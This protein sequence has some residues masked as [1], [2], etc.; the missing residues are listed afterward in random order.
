MASAIPVKRS[1]RQPESGNPVSIPRA[2]S[3][4]SAR[5]G[6]G[7]RGF[8]LRLKGWLMERLATEHRCAPPGAA[9]SW[10]PVVASRALTHADAA[11]I[12]ICPECGGHWRLLVQG[13]PLAG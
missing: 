11:D 1:D 8:G 5:C 12:Y 7:A 3:E 2:A 9:V 13:R 6:I 10:M 4:P